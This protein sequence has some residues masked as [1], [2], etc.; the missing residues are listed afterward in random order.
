[1]CSS[2][3]TLTFSSVVFNFQ[4]EEGLTL[5]FQKGEEVQGWFLTSDAGTA[6]AS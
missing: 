2:F 1:M 4:V 5:Y 3:Q 6:K